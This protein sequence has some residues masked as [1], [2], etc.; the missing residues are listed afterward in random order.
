MNNHT[1]KPIILHS[2]YKRAKT[3]SKPFLKEKLT[4]NY[5]N[6]NDNYNRKKY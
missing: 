1:K 6:N 4:L 5:N 2:A 3:N